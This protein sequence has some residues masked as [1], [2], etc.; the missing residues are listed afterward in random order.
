MRPAAGVLLVA[1]PELTE[2]SFVKSVVYLLEHNLNGTLGFIIN[3]PLPS[4][5][6]EIW[7]EVPEGLQDAIAAAEGGPVERSK[8]LLLHGC[9]DLPGAQ[10][11]GLDCGVGGDLDALA[12]RYSRGCDETGP[13]LFLGHSNWAAGQLEEEI[14]QGSWILRPGTRSLLLDNMPPEDLWRLLIENRTRGIPSP[15]VN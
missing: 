10:E 3:R 11:M 15:S 13:R 2:P 7:S 6:G 9:A 14:E 5:L 4:P 8:G 12:E 1:S